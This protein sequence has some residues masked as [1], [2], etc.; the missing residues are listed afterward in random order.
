MGITKYSAECQFTVLPDRWVNGMKVV[1]VNNKTFFQVP[2]CLVRSTRG[3]YIYKFK[4][5]KDMC[6]SMW[7]FQLQMCV[8]SYQ[9]VGASI[10]IRCHV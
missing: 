6:C 10:C 5:Y 2:F 9:W 8:N 1:C 4:L 7:L 3:I